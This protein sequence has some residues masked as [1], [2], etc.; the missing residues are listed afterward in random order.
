[1]LFFI[2]WYVVGISRNPKVINQQKILLCIPNFVIA[3]SC[4]ARSKAICKLN[5]HADEIK[6]NIKR[7]TFTGITTLVILI[8]I[9]MQ[10]QI[11]ALRSQ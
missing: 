1:M 9:N 4:E 6:K 2:Y 11:A 8:L 10:A 5:N 7:V 3:G